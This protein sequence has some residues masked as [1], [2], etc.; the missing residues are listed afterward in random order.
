MLYLGMDVHGKWTTM[1]GF[2]PETGELV[3]RKRVPN[4]PEEMTA[5]LEGL[6]GPL[7]GVMEAGTNS[8]AI[9]RQVERCFE[10][11]VV[12]D[13]VKLW[14][15]KRDRGAKTDRRDALRMAQMLHRGDIA[16]IYI[17]DER[18]QDLRVLV[19]SK[20]R[21]T[22]RV[23]RLVNEIGSQLRSWG[24]VSHKSLLSKGGA[25]QLEQIELPGRSGRILQLWREMLSKAQEIEAELEQAVKQEAALEPDCRLLQT[26][27][28]VGPFTALAMR[29]EVGE[30]R[31]FGS[32]PS[33]VSYTGWA[34]QVI[35]SGEKCS[36]GRLAPWGNRWLRYTLG[37]LANRIANSRTDNRLRRLY[38]RAC[39][40]GHDS[41]AAK[42]AVARKA[43]ELMWHMLTHQKPWQDLPEEEKRA[44]LPV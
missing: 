33:L 37:L 35:Q 25:E 14:D 6:P 8:W 21:A 12:A 16:G 40:R 5:V 18:T 20:V 32:P 29:A 43:V 41:N 28:T 13:P 3:E 15:R 26:A 7:H 44:T 36:Y 10:E 9:Y 38:W 19:R 22:R 31:R 24:H 42:S 23:T 2:D 34:P 27:P 30:I 1:V 17:P 11:L 39:L 4:E